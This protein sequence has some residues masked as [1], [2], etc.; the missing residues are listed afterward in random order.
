MVRHITNN[1]TLIN[2][3]LSVTVI[4][5]KM[6]YATLLYLR[7]ILGLILLLAAH[8]WESSIALWYETELRGFSLNRAD[9][10]RAALVGVGSFNYLMGLRGMNDFE[11]LL[12]T[13]LIINVG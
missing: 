7:G 9:Y 11:L 3:T 12:I 13:R 6:K 4:H 2:Q 1:G 8:K 10:I 5:A